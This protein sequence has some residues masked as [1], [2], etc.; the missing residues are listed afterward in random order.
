MEKFEAAIQSSGSGQGGALVPVPPEVVEA[1][2]GGGRIPV[3]ATFDGVAYSGSIVAMGAGPSIGIL[4][5]IRTEIGKEPGDTVVVT[6]ERDTAER[7]VDVPGD[8]AAALAA[9]GAREAFDKL[10]Y[11]HRRE[12]VN[13]VN[14]AKKPETRQ[15]RIANAVAMVKR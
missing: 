11:S 9:A 13:A 4:K 7:T 3:K 12:H 5:S 8:L 15:R 6:L 14:E 2:G 1:L 10:S